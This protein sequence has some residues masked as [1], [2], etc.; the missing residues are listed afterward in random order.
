M[1]HYAHFLLLTVLLL[2]VFRDFLHT[3]G[4]VGGDWPYFYREQLSEMPL[5]APAWNSFFNLGSVTVSPW[6]DTYL[7]IIVYIFVNTLGISWGIVQLLFFYFLAIILSAISAT[8][9]YKTLFRTTS[10]LPA[11][12]YTVNTYFL[13]I[14]GGGQL[15]IVLGYSVAPLV[16]AAFIRAVEKTNLASG[17]LVGLAIS[18]QMLFEMRMAYVTIMA[19]GLYWLYFQLLRKHH[20]LREIALSI[21]TTAV[22]PG[23]I[24]FLLHAFWLL[25]NIFFSVDP[26]EVIGSA[27][28]TEAAVRFFSFAEFE[29][30]LSLLHP[31]WPE[32]VF[33]KVSFMKPEF[34]FIPVLAFAFLLFINKTTHVG[35]I[36]KLLFFALLACIGAFLAKGA[37][38]P[39]GEVYIWLFQNIPGFFMF[40][41]STK[42]Y[43]LIA[44]AY[45]VLIPFSVHAASTWIDA[46]IHTQNKKSRLSV[47]NYLY[48]LLPA[49]VVLYVLFLVRPI[50]L[51]QLTG[52]FKR[53]EVP[54]EYIVLKDFL[55]EQPG[56]HRTFWIPQRQRFGYYSKQHPAINAQDFLHATSSAD[57]LRQLQAQGAA[58]DLREA[59]VKYVIVPYDSLGE[60][61][62]EDRKYDERQYNATIAGLEKIP[63]LKREMDTAFGNIAVFALSDPV[64]RFRS[65]E[66]NGLVWRRVS[67]SAYE[68]EPQNDTIKR[69]IFSEQYSPYWVAESEG[70]IG[71]AERYHKEYS[72]FPVQTAETV[73]V[74]YKPE[75][76]VVIGSIISIITL[77]IIFGFL[78]VR[79]KYA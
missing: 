43:V 1:K 58:Q 11:I 66:G 41:D 75:R 13:L 77:L 24:L 25:P 39:F 79:R 21:V 55:D 76:Y 35:T 15:G 67:S 70:S 50:L 74:Y 7:S 9:L 23:T 65:E 69:L 56:F 3:G 32:N 38:D 68:I 54:N 28:N 4:L 57:V 20:S 18:L 14:I 47:K 17:L 62:L 6:I 42:F 64:D 10:I 33:G 27:R 26:K 12:V 72:S 59:S 16:I 51:H 71:E 44:M 31:Y 46:K 48:M 60:I 61:F 36:R 34:L 5:V 19:A 29:Q 8:V 2:V 22:L 49:V 40:R 30:T 37:N 63:W 78:I 53:H 52:T 45:S 73:S